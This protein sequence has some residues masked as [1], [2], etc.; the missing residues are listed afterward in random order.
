V[1]S[2]GSYSTSTSNGSG[3]GT[4]KTFV[5]P[6]PTSV[7]AQGQEAV[8]YPQVTVVDAAGNALTA[9]STAGLSVDDK[10][11]V[12]NVTLTL[13]T[14]P[15]YLAGDG[16]N[17][18]N[19]ATAGDIEVDATIT[20]LGSG[21]NAATVA[22]LDAASK[23]VNATSSGSGNGTYRFF[24][25]RSNGPVLSGQSG[26]VT[27]SV[28]AADNLGN[29][30]TAVAS[31]LK[32]AIDGQAPAVNSATTDKGY[33]SSV[34]ANPP[35]ALVTVNVNDVGPSGLS[36]SN[37]RLLANGHNYPAAAAP[38]STNGGGNYTYAVP[39][40]DLGQGSGFTGT[41]GFT[42]SVKDNAGNATTSTQSNL[43]TQVITLDNVPP[44]Y[45]SFNAVGLTGGFYGPSSTPTI[46]AQVVD[47][48]AAGVDGTTVKMGV[49]SSSSTPTQG[50]LAGSAAT[51]APTVAS[52][53]SS[54]SQGPVQLRFVASDKAGNGV[55]DTSFSV[56]VDLKAPVVGAVNIPQNVAPNS[57]GWYPY[58]ASGTLTIPV[59][60]DVDDG[61]G[62]SGA[63]SAGLQIGSYG[64]STTSTSASL[65]GT[66]RRYTFNVPLNLSQANGK[67]VTLTPTAATGSDA[68]SNQGSATATILN[69]AA[70]KIDGQP[71]QIS[72]V[73]FVGGVTGQDGNPW[74]AYSA[75]GKLQVR[76]SIV[77]GG[78]GVATAS[79]MLV[80]HGTS[81]RLDDG[82]PTQPAGATSTTWTFNVAQSLV[83]AN[84]EGTVAFDVV[85][86]DNAGNVATS[87][88]GGSGY[89]FGLDDKPPTVTFSIGN[90]YPAPGANCGAGTVCGHDGAHFWRQ[91]PT[92]PTL[93]YTVKDGGVGAAQVGT[94]AVVSGAS[95]SASFQSVGAAG[96]T[97]QFPFDPSTPTAFTSDSDGNGTSTISVTGQDLLG[98]GPTH[99]TSIS[100]TAAITR[101]KWARTGLGIGKLKVS[102]VYTPAVD[103]NGTRMLLVGGD[104]TG[105]ATNS[106]VAIVAAN[107]SGSGLGGQAGGAA[108]G[109]TPITN[110]M[111]YSPVTKTL[112]AG[113][114]AAS[115]LLA[116]PLSVS[117]FGTTFSCDL[118]GNAGPS[119]SISGS[120][121]VLTNGASDYVFLSEQDTGDVPNSHRLYV[122]VA[123]GTNCRTGA[124][125]P[126]TIGTGVVR[127]PSTDG[128]NVYV[129]YQDT[130]IAKV[131]F[132]T[133]TGF[134]AV[135]TKDMSFAAPLG[136]PA[137]VG[138][139]F[140]MAD[141]KNYQAYP[142]DLSTTGIWSTPATNGRMSAIITAGPVVAN[143]LLYGAAGSG[144]GSLRAFNTSDGS[145]AFAFA[146]GVANSQV[147]LGLDGTVYFTDGK[148][149]LNAV[150]RNGSGA[151]LAGSWSAPFNGKNI[152]NFP[153]IAFTAAPPEPTLASDGTL[154]FAADNAVYAVITEPVKSPIT[155]TGW[156]RIGFD[157]CN[158]NNSSA[159]NCQ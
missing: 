82:N 140:Y 62:G 137:I 58:D 116:L 158:S 57:N 53:Q 99:Q 107:N 55:A 143:S 115:S 123:N 6:L 110:N 145:P 124:F 125:S 46:T 127:S 81:A 153:L 87:T 41:V 12:I 11:P 152:T 2:S 15:D 89:V 154:Y 44:G 51:F 83:G 155:I 101:F 159:T 26:S 100:Q 73:T 27:F 122:G 3:S 112:Y 91:E 66:A 79:P 77:D 72:G 120:P 121:A 32:I 23:Q 136:G 20:D 38:T 90:E 56:P 33:Y 142:V 50:S 113:A 22:L 80:T 70:L 111:A 64:P 29:P 54:G 37:V 134:G 128:A 25:K 148:N 92:I 49:A 13:V 47:A 93:T 104:N 97:M 28:V 131:S 18:F 10:G 67:E 43:A 71:P 139:D 30:A 17:Y 36:A 109:V 9:T 102:P 114:E 45:S 68:V 21:V 108:G 130:G 146:T 31:T 69:A 133:T 42:M 48:G 1:L 105:G 8:V 129:T 4:A 85:A 106:I 74:Y 118:S 156:P 86:S 132:S 88:N 103:T 75:S 34:I 144:D 14:T 94:Y 119:A 63:A 141:F 151:S 138:A 126:V 35:N 147:A 65:A 52:L 84:Q 95:G 61:S 19:Q 135:V 157:N 76:V 96:V 39:V 150:L 40:T 149:E 117:G 78:S 98:A 16:T 60:V 7:G 24:I 5:L 59:T